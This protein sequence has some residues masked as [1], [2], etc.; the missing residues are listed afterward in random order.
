MPTARRSQRSAVSG[1]QRNLPLATTSSPATRHSRQ[2]VMLE[3]RKTKP[4]SSDRKSS[5]VKSN[6]CRKR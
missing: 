1:S 6:R 4:P 5:M 2:S 3:R